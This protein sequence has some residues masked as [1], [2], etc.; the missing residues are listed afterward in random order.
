MRKFVFNKLVRDKIVEQQQKGGA[1]VEHRILDDREYLTA[2]KAKLLEEASEM[3]LEDEDKL[4]AELADLQEVIDCILETIGKSK[5]DVA[6]A[7]AKKNDKAGSFKKR[8]YISSV[9]VQDEDP[10]VEYYQKNSDRYPE[11]KIS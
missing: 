5:K 3:E 2:L 7:Q 4:V 10:W 1:K 9:T 11:V 8:I 6:L